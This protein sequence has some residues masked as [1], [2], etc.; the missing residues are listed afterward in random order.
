MWVLVVDLADAPPPVL[1]DA[2]PPV[3]AD[4]PPVLE[5]CDGGAD[6]VPGG[7]GCAGLG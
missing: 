7:L 1:A 5:L 2:P 4:A 6:N 3:L